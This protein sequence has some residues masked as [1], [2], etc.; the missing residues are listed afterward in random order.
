MP[1][2]FENKGVYH[3]RLREK[4]PIVLKFTGEIQ[5]SKFD[6]TKEVVPFE[7]RGD[8]TTYWLTVDNDGIRDEINAVQQGQYVQVNADGTYED[9]R[10]NITDPNTGGGDRGGSQAVEGG[11][12]S[13]SRGSVKENY[14]AVLEAVRDL[15]GAVDEDGNLT[16]MGQ[17]HAATVFIQ[18]TRTDYTMPLTQEDVND[19]GDDDVDTS[20]SADGQDVASDTQLEVV[21]EFVEKIPSWVG[22]AHDGSDLQDVKQKLDDL[23]ENGGTV[24]QASNSIK[25]LREEN[26]HQQQGVAGDDELPF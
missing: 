20:D 11:G 24:E 9:A 15:D 1:K 23:I 13:H 12:M 2:T 8:G 18:W 14:R 26:E 6:D 4:S 3:S 19:N 10:L 22:E 5:T 21:S 17:D 16:P 25:W 7:V